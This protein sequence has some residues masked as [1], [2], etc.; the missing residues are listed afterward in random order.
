MR[1]DHCARSSALDVDATRRSA[2]E[3]TSHEPNSEPERASNFSVAG[4]L[5]HAEARVADIVA[6]NINQMPGAIVHASAA[7][8][9]AVTLEADDPAEVL[10]RLSEIQRLPGVM[11]AALVSEHSAPLDT[12]DEELTNE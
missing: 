10:A 4:V 1:S 12:I 5:V 7:G 9:L 3:T 11:S 8:K 6:A 2:R